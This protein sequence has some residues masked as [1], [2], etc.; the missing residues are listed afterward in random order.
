MEDFKY[1]LKELGKS[2]TLIKITKSIVNGYVE[3]T[4]TQQQI[5]AIIQP[6][7]ATELAFLPDAGFTTED[8]KAY[9]APDISVDVGDLIEHDNKRYK[10]HSVEKNDA[11]QKLLLKKVP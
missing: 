5:T 2:V 10:V 6:L 8:L 3:T 9:I 1:I 4:E 7:K 11:Y